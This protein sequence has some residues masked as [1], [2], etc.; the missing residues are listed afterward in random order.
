M[1]NPFPG[2]NPWLEHPSLWSDVHFRLISA[3]ARYLSPL[4]SPRYYVSVGSQ[5][6]IA[7]TFASPPASRYPDIAIVQ[8]RQAGVSPAHSVLATIAPSVI[9]PA[10][11]ELP[12]PDIVEEIYL[13][14]REAV[15]GQVVTVGEVLSPTNKRPGVGRQKY[16]RKRM[17][18]LSTQ[19]HLVEIDLL[20]A[21]PPLPM[22]GEHIASDYRILV[23]RGEQGNQAALYAFNLCDSIPVFHIPLQ[24]G[25]DEPAIDLRQLLDEVYLEANYGVRVNYRQPP[26]PPLSEADAGWVSELAQRYLR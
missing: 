21:W 19:T 2:M 7:T 5:A 20:R 6:Y 10:L 17:E 9:E 16:E 13:E 23:R 3:L 18:I 11:V 22:T 15:T 1:D 12:I 8:S 25:D 24:P 4:V 14:I 26:E